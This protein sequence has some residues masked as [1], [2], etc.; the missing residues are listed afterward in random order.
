MCILLY[1]KRK[2]KEYN[3]SVGNSQINL[4][5]DLLENGHG[6]SDKKG[7][8][9]SHTESELAIKN[10]LFSSG[11]KNSKSL[12]P[13]RYLEQTNEVFENPTF[14][15][16]NIQKNAE[17]AVEILNEKLLTEKGELVKLA[18]IRKLTNEDGLS[19]STNNLKNL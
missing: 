8:K 3:K 1:R 17:E 9:K 2:Q 10:L 5:T 4:L 11:L 15:A 19:V 16:S 14:Q 18:V 13:L 7:I 12:V 6:T